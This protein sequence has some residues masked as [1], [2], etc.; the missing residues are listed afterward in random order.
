VKP[1]QTRT[2]PLAKKIDKPKAKWVEPRVLVNVEY[3]AKTNA[4]GLLRHPS[5]K[6][7]R[8]DLMAELAPRGRRRATRNNR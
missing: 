6:G 5:F 8:R 7:V 1:L 3:R 2:S 4:S